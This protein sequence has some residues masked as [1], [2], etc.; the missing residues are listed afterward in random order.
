MSEVRD[1]A[2]LT[3]TCPDRPG[4]VA[5]V[6]DRVAGLR[7]NIVHADQHTDRATGTFLQRIEL[8]GTDD[9]S[10][11]ESSMADLA[12]DWGMDLRLHRSTGPARLVLLVSGQLHCAA[13]LLMRIGLGEMD[14]EVVGL[15][16]DRPEG[17]SLA[18]MH[19]LPWTHLPIADDRA[20]QEEQLGA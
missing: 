8:D 10:P 15:V 12:V 9:W 5:A 3:I 18:A 11:L 7:I 17:E 2:V 20:A 16:G 14:L 6:A 1:A 4:I 19:G 13:D